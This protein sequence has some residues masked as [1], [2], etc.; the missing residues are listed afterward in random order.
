MMSGL[1]DRPDLD[2]RRWSFGGAAFIETSAGVLSPRVLVIGPDHAALDAWLMPSPENGLPSDE[3]GPEFDDVIVTDDQGLRYTLQTVGMS[4]SHG[5]S[6]QARE[7]MSLR[8]GLDPIPTRECGWI[9]LRNQDGVATRLLPSAR[10]AGRQGGPT[11]SLDLGTDLPIVDDTAVRLDCL[12][13]EP[14]SWSV[15][16]RA[17]PGWWTY[18]EDRHRKWAAMSLEAEDD[19][20]GRYLS[21]FGGSTGH[22]DYEEVILRLLPRLDP[23]ARTLKLIFSGAGERVVIEFQL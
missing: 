11:P 21:T 10:P 6:G 20:G 7:P 18:S 17:A 5:R 8:L 3:S 13:S 9:E 1:P 15:Y 22:G 4:I 2:Q 23:L 14:E 19:L 16:L 12:V